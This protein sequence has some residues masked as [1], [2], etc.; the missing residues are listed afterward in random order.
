MIKTQSP[1]PYGQKRFAWEHGSSL[2]GN[3]LMP[4]LRPPGLEATL[5]TCQSIKC[6]LFASIIFVQMNVKCWHSRNPWNK[7][8]IHHTNTHENVAIDPD[9]KALFYSICFWTNH[10]LWQEVL[11]SSFQLT[12][13]MG[14]ST[15]LCRWLNALE[16]LSTI[17][18][19]WLFL[20]QN[21]SVSC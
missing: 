9:I 7:C 21:G 17:V 12:N 10:W 14:L 15:I 11:A 18:G 19:I 2:A 3:H 4:D 16:S 6:G 13:S 1:P 5:K 8:I 20:S